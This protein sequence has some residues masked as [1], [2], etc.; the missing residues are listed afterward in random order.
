[1]NSSSK[2]DTRSNSKDFI[3]FCQD[4]S[5]DKISDNKSELQ[6]IFTS[7]HTISLMY[8]SLIQTITTICINGIFSTVIFKEYLKYIITRC[9]IIQHWIYQLKPLC[10]NYK[11][12][13]VVISNSYSKDFIEQYYTIK[14]DCIREYI[15][16]Y[17][18]N[19]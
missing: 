9:L 7:L 11:F 3:E 17:S 12:D 14:E 13:S 1:M 8:M 16:T 15:D 5:I 4:T 2:S 19:E 18:Y 6:S 10:K